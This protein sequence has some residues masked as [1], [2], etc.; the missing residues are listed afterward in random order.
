VEQM[1]EVNHCLTERVGV[2]DAKS[3]KF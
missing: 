3:R 2:R 1:G